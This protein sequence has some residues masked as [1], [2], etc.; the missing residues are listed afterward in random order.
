MASCNQRLYSVDFSSEEIKDAKEKGQLLSMEIEFSSRCNFVCPYCYSQKHLMCDQEMTQDEIKDVLAQAHNLGARKIIIL[1]GE[2]LLYPYIFNMIDFIRGLNMG[3]EMFTNGSQLTDDVAKKLFS[4]GV[5]VVMKMNSFKEET[6]DLLTGVNG[7][8]WLIKDA[9]DI[10]KRAGYPSENRYLAV[11]T[12]ICTH[13]IDEL[14]QIWIWL[15]DQNII[16][17]FEMLTP[18][19]RFNKNKWLAVDS[20]RVQNLFQEIAEIDRS[21]YGY[22]WDPQPPLVG[23]QCFRH[24]Y[25]C[26][27]TSLGDVFPCVGVTVSLGNIRNKSLSEILSTSEIIED[28]KN[29]K[30]TIKGPCRTCNQFDK[31]YGCRGAAYQ[32]TGDYLASDPMCWKNQNKQEQ[33]ARLPISAEHIIPQKF[34][35]RVINSLVS[36]SDRKAEAVIFISNDMFFVGEDGVVDSSVYIEMIAQTIAAHN[37]FKKLGNDDLN[38]EGF[39]LGA[40]NFK[41]TG[42]ARVGDKLS[43]II[44]KKARFGNFAILEG[45]ILKNGQMIA[46]GETKIWHNEQTQEGK[47]TSVQ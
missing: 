12:V 4:C 10:L 47:V 5:N 23:S 18:Q 40:K 13:N 36:V 35:M 32:M 28:L 45:A 25:S 33:I 24:Q 15:R 31:C 22:D 38:T 43:I 41:I 7:S 6:Q 3:I 16:P 20:P 34:P 8:F 9:F 2:P 44:E 42:E 26:L 1:G 27:V 37:G 30:Q 21:R 17:Y 19:G 39:L 11:S 29:Y 46:Q 14:A